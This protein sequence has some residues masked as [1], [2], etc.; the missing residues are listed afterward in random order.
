MATCG[1]SAW[2]PRGREPLSKTPEKTKREARTR[3][4]RTPDTPLG[5]YLIIGIELTHVAGI[6]GTH[7]LALTLYPYPS[8]ACRWTI[9]HKLP[10]RRVLR[11]AI[12][13]WHVAGVIVKTKSSDGQLHYLLTLT[14]V[15]ACRPTNRQNRPATPGSRTSDPQAGSGWGLGLACQ[16]GD[17]S[18]PDPL[19]TDRAIDG[20]GPLGDQRRSG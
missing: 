17:H 11:W 7:F 13:L 3:P 8:C 18:G 5:S 20:D 15:T 14:P 6:I 16:G 2:A 10:K 9:R 4:S 1:T 12:M 19:A